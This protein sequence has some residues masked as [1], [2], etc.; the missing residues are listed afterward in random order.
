MLGCC[1]DLLP[2]LV[3]LYTLMLVITSAEHVLKLVTQNR[4]L[5]DQL[6]VGTL[7]AEAALVKLDLEAL[8]LRNLTEFLWVKCQ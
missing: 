6:A 2:K 4:R 8:Q 7:Q 5:L 1:R 3:P